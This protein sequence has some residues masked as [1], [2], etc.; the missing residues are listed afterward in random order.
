[1]SNDLTLYGSF[2]QEIKD[3]TDGLCEV[4]LK[5]LMKNALLA[6]KNTRD[7]DAWSELGFAGTVAHN[8]LVGMALPSAVDRIPRRR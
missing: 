8:G 7:Y 1:M 4:T 6:K 3:L 2:I 5:T